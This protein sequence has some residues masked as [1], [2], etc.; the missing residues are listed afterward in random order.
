MADKYTCKGT[1]EKQKLIS[2]REYDRLML[3]EKCREILIKAMGT[4]RPCPREFK[5]A[6]PDLPCYSASR[7]Y[8]EDCWKQAI[9]SYGVEV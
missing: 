4:P 5:L 7:K 2:Q 6:E 3:A 1:G 9:L 8:C